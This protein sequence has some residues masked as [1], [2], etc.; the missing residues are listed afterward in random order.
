G[1]P[2]FLAHEVG[3]AAGYLD[4]TDF[5]DRIAREWG[6]SLEDDDDIGFLTPR[7]LRAVHRELPDVPA[8]DRTLVLFASGVDKTLARSHARH[9]RPLREFLAG[10]RC[11]ALPRIRA[12]MAS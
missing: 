6:A 4:A 1:R 11:P 3:A 7:E 10:V 2:A 8:D 5:V 9:A 12:R